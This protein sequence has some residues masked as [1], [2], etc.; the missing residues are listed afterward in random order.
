MILVTRGLDEFLQILERNPVVEVSFDK[1]RGDQGRRVVT[2]NEKDADI[3]R[4]IDQLTKAGNF[5]RCGRR[6]IF[7]QGTHIDA[8][9]GRFAVA[10]LGASDGQDHVVVDGGREV[11]IAGELVDLLQGLG[12]IDVAVFA[13]DH[14]RY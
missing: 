1:I 13:F 8:R 3:R 11:D 5:F 12:V 4:F 6:V 9:G 2:R 10:R 14:H 7:H